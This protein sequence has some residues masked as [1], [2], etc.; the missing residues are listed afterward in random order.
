[1]I[2]LSCTNVYKKL[3]IYKKLLKLY[4]KLSNYSYTAK[5]PVCIANSNVW[6]LLR[7]LS[8]TQYCQ[9][10]WGE[11][12]VGGCGNMLEEEFQLIGAQW[13]FIVSLTCISLKGNDIDYLSMC[14]FAINVSS[15][16]KF[17]C[18]SFAHIFI[19]LYDFLIENSL[20][21]LNTSTFPRIWLLPIHSFSQLL[22]SFFIASF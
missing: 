22:L 18:K 2:L 13:C 9:D 15:L 8:S 10:F 21:I 19:G 17:I 7:I 3:A 12:G 16:V 4:K 20:Y 14:S 6:K 11:G 5:P 1:M